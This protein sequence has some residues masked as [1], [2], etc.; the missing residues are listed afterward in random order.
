MEWNGMLLAFFQEIENQNLTK[1]AILIFNV[2]N[3]QIFYSILFFLL[4]YTGLDI[5]M[6]ELIVLFSISCDAV[7]QSVWM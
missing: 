6:N 4:S 7:N 2:K 1:L 3:V 5:Y